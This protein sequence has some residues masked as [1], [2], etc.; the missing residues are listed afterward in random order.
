MAGDDSRLE[1]VM[2]ALLL[3]GMRGMGQKEQIVLLD[4]VGFG[5]KEIA[6]LLGSTSKAISVRLAEIRRAARSVVRSETAG[7]KR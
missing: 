6:G 2:T 5:Q 1:R 7:G 3:V 4:R